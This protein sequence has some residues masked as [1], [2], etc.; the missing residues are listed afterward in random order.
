MIWYIVVLVLVLVIVV[1]IYGPQIIV[2]AVDFTD[3]LGRELAEFVEECIDDWRF[4]FKDMKEWIKEK[5]REKR[6]EKNEN[7]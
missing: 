1:F 3:G 5:H 4:V 6:G 2:F 7:S